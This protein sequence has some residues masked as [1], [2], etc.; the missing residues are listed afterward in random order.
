MPR[1]TILISN[2]FHF[3]APVALGAALEVVILAAATD[4]AAIREVKAVA[5]LLPL[6]VL[7]TLRS[8]SRTLLLLVLA[9]L[10][11]AGVVLLFRRGTITFTFRAWAL[12]YCG[13]CWDEAFSCR[14]ERQLMCLELGS[15]WLELWWCSK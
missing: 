13:E 1:L 10:R 5:R 9:P 4:P 12:A 15:S 2:I 11:A 6:Y 8:S 7:A 3:L 14:F